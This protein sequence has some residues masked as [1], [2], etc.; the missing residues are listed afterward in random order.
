M[1]EECIESGGPMVQPGDEERLPQN[2]AILGGR[3]SGGRPAGLDAPPSD[4][5][6]GIR[7][8]AP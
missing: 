3:A 2:V 7:I 6:Q 8:S 1:E 5:S 4:T